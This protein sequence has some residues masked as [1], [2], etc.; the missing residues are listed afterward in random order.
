MSHL[1]C[2]LGGSTDMPLSIKGLSWI[3]NQRNTKLDACV[4]G[5]EKSC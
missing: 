5:V 1:T 4:L 3:E 2:L